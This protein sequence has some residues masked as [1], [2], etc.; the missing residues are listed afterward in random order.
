MNDVIK[1]KLA[2][3]THSSGVYIMKAKDGT[4]IY[5][6]KAKNLKNRVSQYFLNK[7]ANFFSLYVCCI[8]R[9]AQWCDPYVF[10]YYFFFSTFLYEFY[11]LLWI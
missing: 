10:T 3:I 9:V 6:G 8:L 1:Q 2:N 11:N 7:N 4:V 5:V